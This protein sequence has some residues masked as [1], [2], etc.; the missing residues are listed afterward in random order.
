MPSAALSSILT[1][2]GNHYICKLRDRA[3]IG[4][5]GATLQYRGRCDQPAVGS[6]ALT[7]LEPPEHY[8]LHFLNLK[9][10]ESLLDFDAHAMLRQMRA[11]NT[12]LVHIHALLK[13]ASD[14]VETQSVLR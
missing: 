2:I 5:A 4:K 12:E 9:P 1:Q 8:S 13:G 3:H 6:P 10:H 14:T 7:R 11:N